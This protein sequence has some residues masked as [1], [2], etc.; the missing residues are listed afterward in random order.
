MANV[1]S[2]RIGYVTE[3][4][5]P[6]ERVAALGIKYVEMVLKEGENADQV[7]ALLDPHGLKVSTI[8][9]HPTPVSDDSILETMAQATEF[10][11]AVGA[12]GFFVSVLAG[13]TPLDE[14][15]TRLRQVGEIAGSR[16]LFVAM[17]THED[18]CENAAKAIQTLEAVNHPAFGW[19]LDTANIYYYN[20]NIDVVEEARKAAKWVRSVH[21]K[22]TTG[23]FKD[24]N[25]PNLGE[26]IVDF[27]GVGKALAAVGFDGPY[28][29]ELEGVAGSAGSVEEMERNVGLCAE[30]LRSLG[31]VD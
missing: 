29:M 14:A 17:E 26:G 8:H 2:H 21:A 10:A 18:L 6:L 30:H 12:K 11:L 7:L 13:E 27:A 15:Y 24:P 31:L 20:E 3:P 25:F 1:L 23:G 19:N 4:Q 16:G 28:T 9:A 22:D 5:L